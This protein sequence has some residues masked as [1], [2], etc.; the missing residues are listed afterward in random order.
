ML[1]LNPELRS[2]RKGGNEGS[3]VTDPGSCSARTRPL[4]LGRCEAPTQSDPRQGFTAK[5]GLFVLD[6]ERSTTF[7]LFSRASTCW[8]RR[9]SLDYRGAEC[10]QWMWKVS[11]CHRYVESL[12]VH[13]SMAVAPLPSPPCI[14]AGVDLS[15]PGGT[16]LTDRQASALAQR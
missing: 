7:A 4:T 3:T 16:C 9:R 13:E 5:T 11:F 8:S 12:V 6:D 1:T 14:G 15:R 10:R 2:R